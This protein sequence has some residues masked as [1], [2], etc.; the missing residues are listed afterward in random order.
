MSLAVCVQPRQAGLQGSA[1]KTRNIDPCLDNPRS[2]VHFFVV[3]TMRSNQVPKTRQT[4]THVV[5]LWDQCSEVC[6]CSVHFWA[7]SW[8]AQPCC[9]PVTR[10]WRLPQINC[11]I[12]ANAQGRVGVMGFED[13]CYSSTCRTSVLSIKI[14]M[15]PCL[16]IG[17]KLYYMV[18][19][20]V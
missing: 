13:K 17:F 14:N 19:D 11:Y 8:Q 16:L 1:H 20:D 12:I 4:L 6:R 2:C 3:H 15:L 9:Y 10:D 5:E 7:L 18:P